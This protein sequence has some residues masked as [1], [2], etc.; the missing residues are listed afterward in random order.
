MKLYDIIKSK[1]WNEHKNEK[2]RLY[3]NYAKRLARMLR[4]CRRY[5][6][7][8]EEENKKASQEKKE[9]TN[10]NKQIT[11]KEEVSEEN[12]AMTEKN[13]SEEAETEKEK[14]ETPRQRIK[15]IRKVSNSMHDRI[16]RTLKYR[17]NR[18][19]NSNECAQKIIK[20]NRQTLILKYIGSFK[21]LNQETFKQI[22]NKYPL[23]LKY[24]NDERISVT[25][26]LLKNLN[27]FKDLD[28]RLIQKI[29]EIC[30]HQH[31]TL[32][33][34]FQKRKHFK[35]IENLTDEEIKLWYGSVSSYTKNKYKTREEFKK[36]LL[37]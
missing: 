16:K 8:K 17:F 11:M 37:K 34:L 33:L 6:D 14:K 28:Y 20:E 1:E 3:P 29:I 18:Y 21:N 7:Q 36:V 25:K 35:W 10:E 23:G 19:W 26:I 22:L 32:E 13:R 24:K 27:S 15:R 4:N 2:N 5:E 31:W 12:Q 9:I 30:N